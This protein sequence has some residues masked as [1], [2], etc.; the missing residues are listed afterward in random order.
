MGAP[1][2]KPEDSEG[3]QHS[4]TASTPRISSRPPAEESRLLSHRQSG[5]RPEPG[6]A[7]VT[8]AGLGA[9]A[10]PGRGVGH[11]PSLTA[12]PPTGR[13]GL[14]PGTIEGTKAQ[15]NEMPGPAPMACWDESKPGFAPTSAAPGP[16]SVPW[17]GGA[18]C[19]PIRARTPAQTLS[20]LL[21]P[22]ASLSLVQPPPPQAP[23]PSHCRP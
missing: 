13:L 8:A 15:G 19:S 2:R 7:A 12:Q 21:T 23:P 3:S 6:G 4:D 20:S 14:A 1:P 22:Q 11:R 16:H 18:P 5:H 17:A 10:G 9:R